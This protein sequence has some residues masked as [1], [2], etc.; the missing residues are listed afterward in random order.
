MCINLSSLPDDAWRVVLFLLP[1]RDQLRATS[2]CKHL[3]RCIYEMRLT[4]R[5]RGGASSE[6][7]LAS[8]VRAAASPRL[9]GLETIDLSRQEVVTDAVLAALAGA[10]RS[11]TIKTLVLSN[12]KHITDV[13][14]AALV[15]KCPALST[16]D[17]SSTAATVAALAG[18]FSTLECL[19]LGGTSVTGARIAALVAQCSGLAR[20]GLD[21]C[22]RATGDDVAA[23]ASTLPEL[24][25]DFLGMRYHQGRRSFLTKAGLKVAVVEW[26]TS[27]AAAT[28]KFGEIA[29][30]DVSQITDMSQVAPIHATSCWSVP[31][32]HRRSPRIPP[33]RHRSAMFSTASSFNG[34]VSTWDVS[35]VEDMR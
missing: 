35:N 17:L 27:E 12:C 4:V 29:G 28:A 34:D 13:G 31:T 6:R 2:T 23:L 24:E 21:G 33:L 15:A 14:I 7:A 9:Q 10:V 8:L 5:W 30:W 20:L 26:S 3:F 22:K 11:T 19:D 25:I 1:P 18:C 16:L 32:P